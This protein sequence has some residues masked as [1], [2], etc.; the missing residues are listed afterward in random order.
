MGFLMGCL[1]LGFIAKSIWSLLV[2]NEEGQKLSTEIKDK[3]LQW[4][5]LSLWLAFFLMFFVGIFVPALG[6]QKFLSSGWDIWQVGLVGF[7]AG[8]PVFT[9]VDRLDKK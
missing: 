8:W 2:R 3:P 9:L 6:E 5:V 7:F 1:L 4:L